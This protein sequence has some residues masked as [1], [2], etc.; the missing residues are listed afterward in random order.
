M[1]K[2]IVKLTHRPLNNLE[3]VRVS[4]EMGDRAN[5]P[6][7]GK[8]SPHNG[9]D[10]LPSGDL[11]VFA[12]HNG[13]VIR[14]LY[15]VDEKRERRWGN[16]VLINLKLQLTVVILFIL[17]SV[18]LSFALEKQQ[19]SEMKSNMKSSTTKQST[20]EIADPDLK[21]SI[22]ELK[23]KYPIGWLEKKY[24]SSNHPSCGSSDGAFEYDGPI[25]NNLQCSFI[26]LEYNINHKT[27]KTEEIYTPLFS[28][29]D[30]SAS[31]I[32]S[33]FINID[34][35]LKDNRDKGGLVEIDYRIYEICGIVLSYFERNP[36]NALNDREKKLK[37]FIY[38]DQIMERLQKFDECKNIKQNFR[39]KTLECR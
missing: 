26:K 36:L 33:I 7:D 38:S 6:I 29:N 17:P 13:T 21:L 22:D 34:K 15:Q 23:K 25:P 27:N 2:P 20:K 28:F 35:I 24:G 30:F 32:K 3:S 39:L 10:L 11:T 12:T 14:S 19:N 5:H 37:N 9:I 18:N 4:E 8:P 31:E 1:T 16:Y